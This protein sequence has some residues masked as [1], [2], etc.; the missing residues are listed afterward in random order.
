MSSSSVVD[1]HAASAYPTILYVNSQ[2][3]LVSYDNLHFVEQ[4]GRW[5]ASCMA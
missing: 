2:P 4:C 1:V 3:L 5:C